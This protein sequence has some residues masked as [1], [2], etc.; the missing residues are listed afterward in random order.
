M[1]FKK[2]NIIIIMTMIIFSIIVG[3][4]NSIEDKQ[5]KEETKNF[6]IMKENIKKAKMTD[7]MY[8][9]SDYIINNEIKNFFKESINLNLNTKLL[10]KNIKL[11]ENTR[12]IILL[13]KKINR[14]EDYIF[15]K[16]YLKN[17]NNILIIFGINKNI[18]SYLDIDKTNNIIK[19]QGTIIEY[20]KDKEFLN[21]K[22]FLVFD[23]N[24][25]MEYKKQGTIKEYEKTYDL[26]YVKNNVIIINY[27][28]KE[29]KILKELIKDNIF[30]IEEIK[31]TQ[32]I[33]NASK[34]ELITM[35]FIAIIVVFNLALMIIMIV[36][37]SKYKKDLFK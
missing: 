24:L 36:Y 19:K 9:I 34:G 18:L 10:N 11:K 5:I 16:E 23:K 22:K 30:E 27:F 20:K 32:K 35:V 31:E 6:E 33:F 1:M 15:L 26:A 28:S 25:S 12:L 7:N 4:V 37:R 8:L 13:N 21:N 14:K 3:Q 2:I 17:K 29:S